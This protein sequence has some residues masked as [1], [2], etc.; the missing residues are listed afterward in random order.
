M[1]QNIYIPHPDLAPIEEQAA[2]VA[3]WLERHP[4]AGTLFQR[5]IRYVDPEARVECSRGGG[6]SPYLATFRVGRTLAQCMTLGVPRHIVN[7]FLK[8]GWVKI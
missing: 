7:R 1:H 4:P 5:P 6:V 8:R 2:W 3:E